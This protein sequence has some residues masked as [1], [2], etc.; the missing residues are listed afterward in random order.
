[1]RHLKLFQATIDSERRWSRRRSACASTTTRSARR[2]RSFRAL[3]YTKH[4]YDWTPI[5][6]IEDLEK[7]TPA[8]CQQLLRRLLP[9][10][11]RDADR[12]RRHRRGGGAQAGDQH[13]GPSRAARSRRATAEEPPQTRGAR[14]DAAA[15]RCRSRW[16]S[17]AITSRAPADPD[18]P[19]LEVLAAILS[20]GE[21]SRLH[22]RLVRKRPAG[23]RR[24]RRR[25]SRW[26]TGAVHRLRG[27]PARHATRQGA[28]GAGRGDRARARQAGRR[29]TSSTRR[30]T[31]WRPRSCS[32]C[33]PSTASRRRWARRSTSRATG[34]VRRGRDALP[35]GHR[36][37]RAAGR[38]Q[39]PG[40]R[41]T[42]RA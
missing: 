16:S 32:G 10:Q 8:D 2:S 19:A 17:A 18:M 36:R 37:R 30:R 6:T 11:Q 28:G 4:P 5:G 39:V 25:R 27:V 1:M 12:R 24:R 29:R 14:G 31:S 42:S 35:G 22:Q 21:S 15:S 41:A 13:F 3:A 33:R 38:A 23:D 7:V 9:A 26:R 40:R 20:A 34:S